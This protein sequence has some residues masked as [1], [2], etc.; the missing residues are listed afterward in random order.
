MAT[1]LKRIPVEDQEQA[2]SL[3]D[4]LSKEYKLISRTGNPFHVSNEDY[5]V[6]YDPEENAVI[7]EAIHPDFTEER[8]QEFLINFP[9]F[10]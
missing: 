9:P 4:K 6:H 5:S 1:E 2:L 3:I 8:V 7:M 10:F